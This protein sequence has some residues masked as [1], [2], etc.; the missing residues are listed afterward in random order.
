MQRFSARTGW[1]TGESAFASAI[2]RARE[3]GRTLIDLTVSNPTVCGFT[4]DVEAVAGALRDA[5]TLTYDAAP[6]GILPAR[7]AVCGYYADHGAQVDPAQVLLTASTSEAYAYLFRLLCDPRDE[8]LVAQPGY[9]LFDYL[10]DLEDVTLRTYPL[11]YDFGWWIDFDGLERRIGPRT[12]ALVVVHPANPT[13]HWTHAAERERL[14]S[15][16]AERGLALIVDEVFLDYAVDAETGTRTMAAHPAEC[17]TF[18]LSGLSKVAGLPQMKAGWML[19]LG[20]QEAAGEALRRLEV[21]ADTFLSVGAPVQWALPEWLAGRSA[22]QRQIRDR[23]RTNLTSAV[24]SGLD[25]L[26]VEAG[27][28]LVARVPGA[29][30]DVERMLEE[31]GVVV[32]P[33]SFYGLAGPGRVVLSLITPLDQFS[34]GLEL[35]TRA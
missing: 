9:P 24:A 10:A 26:P 28:S 30:G 19:T 12:R 6:L 35:L 16:C 1:D 33:G 5:R 14:F 17:L 2:R 32:H 27:W 15:L 8:V 21:I 18:V 31:R 23:V 20:P 34:R 7:E 25:H 13:G 11:F 22:I 3:S 4:Y 29:H